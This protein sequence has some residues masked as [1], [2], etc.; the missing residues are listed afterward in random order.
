MDLYSPLIAS[1][2]WQIT[3]SIEFLCSLIAILLN[4]DSKYHA[5]IVALISGVLINVHFI[6]F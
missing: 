1:R 6:M 2:I 4:K 3:F 5:I